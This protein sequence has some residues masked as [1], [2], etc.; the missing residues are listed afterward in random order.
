MKKILLIVSAFIGLYSN[1]I[2]TMDR[3]NGWQPIRP[4]NSGHPL[5]PRPQ[6]INYG[7]APIVI[8]QNNTTVPRPPAVADNSAMIFF[9]NPLNAP[10][11]QDA[12]TATETAPVVINPM[13]IITTTPPGTESSSTANAQVKSITPKEHERL[14]KIEKDLDKI[15]EVLKEMGFDLAAT[16]LSAAGLDPIG[17][18]FSASN[19]VITIPKLAYYYG[20]MQKHI[21]YLSSSNTSP[22]AKARL[23]L[24]A[25]RLQKISKIVAKGPE[26]LQKLIKKI[27]KEEPKEAK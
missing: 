17:A 24:L 3:P 27:S 19:S 22:E 4:S 12:L 20:N 6:A 16:A 13:H 9:L 26:K 23:T 21:F 18:A 11:A 7:I 8:N 14:L 15:E 10:Q 2:S 25:P 5:R 1:I